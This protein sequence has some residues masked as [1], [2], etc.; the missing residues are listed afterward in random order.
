M[1]IIL[2]IGVAIAFAGF[3]YFTPV[4]NDILSSF[5]PVMI[6]P[7]TSNITTY[8][9]NGTV[10]YGM[11]TLQNAIGSNFGLWIMLI[12]L[13]YLIYRFVKLFKGTEEAE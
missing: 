8:T 10:I 9:A 7:I 13:G 2:L 5:T 12:A 1:K 3:V 6:T 11:G 4:V